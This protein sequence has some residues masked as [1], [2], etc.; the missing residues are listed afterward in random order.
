MENLETLR[1]THYYSTTCNIMGVITQVL[2]E[3][4]IHGPLRLKRQDSRIDN[5]KN[6][7]F[8]TYPNTVPGLSSLCGV[9]VG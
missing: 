8:I 1:P 3:T 7:S 4:I 5:T 2:V 6:P 9:K